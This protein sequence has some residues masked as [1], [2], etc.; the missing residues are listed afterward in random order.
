M[1]LINFYC[2][3]CLSSLVNSEVFKNPSYELSVVGLCWYLFF[4]SFHECWNMLRKYFLCNSV[5]KYGS[6]HHDNFN[7]TFLKFVNHD[8]IIM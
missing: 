3:V 4:V 7:N 5:R 2:I 1:I 8:E 6:S